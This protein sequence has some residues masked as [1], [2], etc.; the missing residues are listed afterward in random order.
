VQLLEVVGDVPEGTEVEASVDEFNLDV[1]VRYIGRLLQAAR[2][3]AGRP[4]H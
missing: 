3:R 1:R 2:S 4:G